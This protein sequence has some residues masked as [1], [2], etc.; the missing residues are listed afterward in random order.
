MRNNHNINQYD[1]NKIHKWLIKIYGKATH[2]QIEK[3]NK[4]CLVFDYALIKGQS[5]Q[6]DRTKFIMVCRSCH[7]KYDE[8][9]DT[10]KKKGLYHLGRKRSLEARKR[11]SD[12]AKRLGRIPPSRKGKI[13]NGTRPILST[14]KQSQEAT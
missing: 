14:T 1:Y 9:I 7:I 2:C 10:N 4:K 12:A 8:R 13:K 5:Y 6:M 3:C 11:M